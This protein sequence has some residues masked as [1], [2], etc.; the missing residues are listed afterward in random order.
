MD[1]NI[2]IELSKIKILLSLLG[3]IVFIAISLWFILKPEDLV[4]WRNRN[5]TVILTVGIIGIITFSFF[6][7]FIAKK[8]LNS[9]K[10]LIISEEG[11]FEN[12]SAISIGKIFWKDIDEIQTLKI[13]STN[14]I[15]F[16]LKNPDFYIE[17]A[18]NSFVKKALK[19]NYNLCGS[20]IAISSNS[21]KISFTELEKIIRSE[22]NAYKKKNVV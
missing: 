5:E 19:A 12:S 21:L 16:I 18:P 10:G 11:I 3:C 17:L 13:A 20:P 15:I 7:I 6:G 8:L 4:N 9:K 2:E 1:K 22:Y 14:H